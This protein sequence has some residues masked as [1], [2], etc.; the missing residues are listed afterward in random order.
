VNVEIKE[1]YKA[2]NDELLS[3]LEMA[4]AIV[5]SV[6]LLFFF[7]LCVYYLKKKQPV[8]E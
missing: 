4:G 5:A 1:L 2:S 6:F 3:T 8:S 7:V